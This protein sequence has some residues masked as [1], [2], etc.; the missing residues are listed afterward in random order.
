MNEVVIKEKTRDQYGDFHTKLD[1]PRSFIYKYIDYV[2]TKRL[3][4]SGKIYQP[5]SG[6][7][8]YIRKI[9]MTDLS[10]SLG[11]VEIEE[12]NLSATR[13]C[14]TQKFFATDVQ[15]DSGKVVKIFDV[16]V[17]PTTVI[18]GNYIGVGSGTFFGQV[19]LVIQVDPNP[20][21]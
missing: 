14:L 5:G 10:S 9:I 3:A 6:K 16:C 2:S 19:G 12:T 15:Q 21:E 18:S 20:D 7:S 4:L 1:D 17:G 11:W 8:V 13:E